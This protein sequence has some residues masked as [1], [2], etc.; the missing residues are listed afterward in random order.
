M[1][2][3]P[4]TQVAGLVRAT[5]SPATSTKQPGHRAFFVAAAPSATSSQDLAATLLP[6]RSGPGLRCYEIPARGVFSGG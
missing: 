1:T 2:P 6:S 4:A 5:R 3:V